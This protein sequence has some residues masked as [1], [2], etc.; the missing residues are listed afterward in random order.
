MDEN[1][2]RD[3]LDS[4][5][6]KRIRLEKSEEEDFYKATEYLECLLNN[7]KSSRCLDCLSYDDGYE[8]GRDRGYDAGYIDGKKARYT[9]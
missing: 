9:D 3:W 7:S 6:R 2:I 5:D 4:M 8:D 1:D